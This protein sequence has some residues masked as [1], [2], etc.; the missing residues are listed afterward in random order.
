MDPL[1]VKE[2]EKY[3]KIWTQ[4]PEYR[5]NSPAEDLIPLF[6][7][8]FREEIHI[9]QTLLDLGCGPARSTPLLQKAGLAVSLVDISI[10]SLDPEIFIKV[11]RAGSELLFH[12]ESLWELS[13]EIVSADWIICFDVLEHLPEEKIEDV[14]KGIRERMRLGGAFSITLCADLFGE[15][16][17]EQLHL[18]VKPAQW[19]KDHIQRNFIIEEEQLLEDQW[20][21]LFLRPLGLSHQPNCNTA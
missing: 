18:T 14:L 10:N 3:E 7:W 6:L 9:G 5:E 11:H 21:I 15:S 13:S 12:Q 17:G 4:V 20:L 16:I 2:F 1:S 8:H 19:W